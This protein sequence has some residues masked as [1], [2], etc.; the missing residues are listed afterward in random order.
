[1]ASIAAARRTQS[2]YPAYLAAS[3]ASDLVF[4]TYEPQNYAADYNLSRGSSS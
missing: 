3:R 4:E 1:M 2:A